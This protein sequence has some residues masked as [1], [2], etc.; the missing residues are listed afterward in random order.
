MK[1]F[2]KRIFQTF[3]G[4]SLLLLISGFV[5]T[6]F[7]SEKVENKVVSKIQEQMTSE[8]Q[9]G[10]VAFS[11]YEKF[12]S[13]SVKITN[14]LAFEKEGFDNDTLFYAKETYIELS[15]FDIILNKI[16]IK[17]VVVSEGEINIK[18]DYENSPNFAIF[19]TNE[20]SKNQ[21]TLD[22]VLLLNTDI[23]CQTKSIAIN[24]H[25]TQAMLVFK[26]EKLALN[27]KLFSE[28]LKVNSR[29]YIHKKNVKLLATLSLKKDSIFIQEGSI[30][31]IEDVKAELSGGIFHSNTVDLNFS[32]E[33]QELVAVIEHTPEYLKSIYSSF[34]AN[35]KISCNGNIKGL[36]SNESNPSL[37][38][39]CY[40][41]KGNLNLKSRPFILKGVSLSGKITNGD[42][43]NFRTTNI[44]ITQFDA[45]T[46]NGFLKG[47]FTIQ[48]LNKYYL[49]ANLSSSWDLAEINHYFEDSPFFNLQGNLI[50]NTQYS[51]YISFDKKFKNHFL[52]AQHTSSTTF[53]N[54]SFSYKNF[55]LGFNFQSA[56]CVFRNANVVEVKSSAF[57]IADSDLNFDGDI[58]DLIAYILNK[59]DEIDVTGD[60]NSTYI[61]FDEL[62]TLKDLSE[63]KGTGTM[64]TWINANLNTNITTFSYDDFIASEITGTLA[65]KNMTLTGE[66]MLLNS[67]NGNIA[68]NFKFYESANNKLKLF[69]QLN[70]TRL[71][72]RNAFLAF[73]NFKQDFITAKHIKGV[74]TAEIQMQSSWKPGFIFEEEELKV[75]S[76]LIIEKGEL[77]HFKPLE[78]LSDYVSLDDLK[79]VKFST[80][81][82]TIEIDN[83]VITIPTMEIKSSALSV[84]VSGTHTFEQ[85][86]NYR[87]KLLLS[88]LM[89][90]KFRKKNTRIKKTEFGEVEENGKIFNTI[91]FKMTGNSEDPNI[92]FDGIRFREDVQKG[93]TKEKE[94]ITNII[95]EEILLHKEKEKVEQGQDVIIEWDDE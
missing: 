55:P 73:D 64:P 56:N 7:F 70:L 22:N 72:I 37:N 41:E 20:E 79:E 27:A 21:L 71:N 12:P 91:Y 43:Q 58:T 69:S 11:L 66:N 17:T 23:N 48:N 15:I 63:G 13:A 39:S 42:E 53:E 3:L 92:S 35:G 31:H 45:K 74:G 25:T 8:L 86:I 84:F 59:K 50:A 16:D 83:K 80:L 36:V 85:E 33:Q 57:T 47:N 61:K 38:M 62:L 82:N 68:G 34:Q 1:Q 90:T 76:H 77:I 52:R 10:E 60:L 46:E 94:T 67:L 89:S 2:I 4:I 44:E 26:E 54:A 28:I 75:K 88:E 78:S 51:G 65:Y 19:K 9:L 24:L 87:I 18:Y 14:L 30:V 5:V 6:Y 29:D 40:I 95:K 81:E 49:T 32:C 93:I